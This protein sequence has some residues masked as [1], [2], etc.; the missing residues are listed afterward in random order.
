MDRRIILE[1]S[2]Y[3]VEGVIAAKE[4]GADRVE[5]CDNIQEGGTTPSYGMIRQAQAVGLPLFV[6]IRPRGGDFVYSSSE[7]DVML[8]DIALCKQLGVEG[9][10]LGLLLPDGSIDIENTSRLVDAARPMKVTFHRAF[11]MCCDPDA[12]LQQ[13][14]GLGIERI[15]TSGQ[16]NTA[17]EGKEFLAR[18]N[19]NLPEGIKLLIGSGVN[20]GNLKKLHNAI[21]ADE[22]HMSA[23]QYMPSAMEY[24]NP[25]ISMG[26]NED[27]DEFKVL[28]A[29]K[30]KIIQARKVINQL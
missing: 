2:V 30:E 12:A 23:A 15:L 18:L 9:V 16:R 24:I 26:N 4:A 14:A 11:D 17:L 8:D 10:V 13:L 20:A 7:V 3:S 6:I 1:A 25:N 22:Y 28:S 27:M 21:Q 29:N 19:R 5:L